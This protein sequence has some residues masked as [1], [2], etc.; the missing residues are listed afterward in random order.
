MDTSDVPKV[1]APFTD[2]TSGI[3]NFQ[4]TSWNDISLREPDPHQFPTIFVFASV[5][6]FLQMVFIIFHGKSSIEA[7]LLSSA[8]HG[9][10]TILNLATSKLLGT[11]DLSH[12]ED[13]FGAPLPLTPANLIKLIAILAPRL[14]L[15]IAPYA[16]EASELIASHLARDARIRNR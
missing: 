8:H 4:P 2:T 6:V 7:E 9:T 14:S 1:F 10:S 5:D 11:F 16:L 15:T 3:T 12:R 13:S